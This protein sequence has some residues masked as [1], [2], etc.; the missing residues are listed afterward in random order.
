[1]KVKVIIEYEWSDANQ[2]PPL[3]KHH[4]ALEE[5]AMDSIFYM[6]KDGY[7]GGGLNTSV[8]VDDEDEDGVEY[9]GYWSINTKKEI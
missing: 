3:P 5:D 2:K 8:R 9:W 4:E 6:M 7:T 1:M